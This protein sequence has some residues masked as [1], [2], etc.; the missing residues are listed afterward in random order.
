[1]KKTLYC[2]FIALFF[3]ACLVPAAGMGIAGPS[4][5]AANEVPA[6]APRMRDYDGSW[7]PDFL[8]D[9]Q[10]YIGK[11]FFLRL[12]AITGWDALAAKLFRTSGSDDVL[13]GPDGWLFYAGAVGDITGADQLTDRQIWCAARGLY[14]MEEYARS[15]GAR[16]LFTVPCGKYTIYPEHAPAYVTVAEGS[17]RERL[18]AALA[19]M[20][21][22]YADMYPA[23]AGGDET[24]YWKW[25]SHWHGKGAA[26]GADV[27]LIALGRESRYAAGPFTAAESHTGDLYAMLYPRGTAR[28]ADYAPAEPFTFVYTSNFQTYDDMVI[29]TERAGAEGSLLLFRDSS[30]R[31]LYP[32]LAESFGTAY[33]SRANNYRLDQTGT[34][35]ADTVVIELAERTLDYLLKYP[36]V[37]P[38]PARDAAALEGLVPAESEVAASDVD[39]TLAGYQKLTGT[40]PA[41][42]ADSPVYV[43]ADGCLY[44]AIP[45]EGSFTAWLPADIAPEE[46]RVYIV[47]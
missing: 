25:D 17:N 36:A 34:L 47:P 32:Y 22:S 42:A 6:A 16:F 44:E 1:M 9:L 39:G 7:N 11:G 19:A 29:T 8:T 18:Q 14:L 37:Y 23:F 15:Q 45:N 40:I 2:M 28:E 21:V 30:G 12:E 3:A 26:L 46:V 35:G 31:N 20:G 43:Q 33:I 24:L 41:A 38:A 4:E 5:A 10:S 13:I 27:I